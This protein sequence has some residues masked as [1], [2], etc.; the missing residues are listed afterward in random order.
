LE[1]IIIAS[2]GR[3]G[4]DVLSA[5]GVV[6]VSAA[7]ISG[8][9]SVGVTGLAAADISGAEAG[10]SAGAAEFAAD[11]SAGVATFAGAAGLSEVGAEAEGAAEAEVRPEASAGMAT[12]ATEPGFSSVFSVGLLA[13]LSAN[14]GVMPTVP[15][16]KLTNANDTNDLIFIL[17][18]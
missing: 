9:I 7:A 3:T 2:S 16:T 12:S 10:I 15:I 6:C 5:T 8:G 4:A 18:S 14:A 17:L 13:P 1:A 11:I